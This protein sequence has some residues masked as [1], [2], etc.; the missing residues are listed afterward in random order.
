M[1]WRNLGRPWQIDKGDRGLSES[2]LFSEMG[3]RDETLG[4]AGGWE[5]GE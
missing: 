3:S 2:C 4:G 1:D 5:G